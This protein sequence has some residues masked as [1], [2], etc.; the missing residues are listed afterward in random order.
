MLYLVTMHSGP[1][2]FSKDQALTLLEDT[3]L[4]LFEALIKLEAEKKIVAGGVQSGGRS[5][6]LIFSVSSH[7]EL[8]R[9]LRTLPMWAM[10]EWQIAPLLTLADR[11]ETEKEQLRQLKSK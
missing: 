5:C 3:V 8:D 11:F 1:G 4:P 10:T 7:E 9:I 2:F 6:S